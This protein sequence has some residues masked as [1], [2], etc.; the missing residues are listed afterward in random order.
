MGSPIKGRVKRKNTSPW[1]KIKLFFCSSLGGFTKAFTSFC[2][3]FCE[4][5]NL[6]SITAQPRFI[7]VSHPLFLSFRFTVSI[8][9][10]APACQ[11]VADKRRLTC[12]G[13][14]ERRLTCRGVAD[15]RR[16]ITHQVQDK[17]V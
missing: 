1:I 3:S 4:S 12:R 2:K 17:F 13:V 15:K 5:T 8:C 16:L 10:S 7:P 14:A 9:W 11:G 6:I